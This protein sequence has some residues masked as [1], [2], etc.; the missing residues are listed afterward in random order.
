MIE[1]DLLV[2]NGL[3]VT[4]DDRQPVIEDGAV[5]IDQGR[6]VAVGPT[7]EVTG[8]YQAKK[9]L[10]ARRKAVMPGFVD[11][12]H[13]FLQ[14]FH[15]GTRDDLALIEWI[16]N[17][18]VP[19]IRVAVQDYLKGVYDIQIHASKLGC[20]DAIKSGITTIL[21]MEWATH[22]SVVSVFEQAGIRVRHTITMTD[23]WISPEVIMPHDR[24]LALADELLERC[25]SSVNGRVSFSYGLACPNSCSVG[26][27]KEVRAL[28]D[29]NQVPIHIHIAET[30]Y[31]W[32]NIHNLFGATPT[33]HLHN[34]GLLGPDVQGAH[35]IWLSDED[36]ELYRQTGTKVAH[37][38]EC[39][40]KI[41]DGIAPITKMLEAGVVVSLG[42]DSCSVNDNMDMFEAMRTAAFLQKVT[43]MDPAVLPAA[44]TL[45]M[46]TLGGAEAL[47]MENEI[48]SL[49]VGKKADLILV[50]LS[51]SHMRPINNLENSLV[52]CANANDVQTV[53]CDGQVVMEDRQILTLDEEEW[54]S[55]ATRYA[56]ERFTAAGI[57]LPSYYSL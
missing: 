36:I 30:K 51:G 52:Y 54:V 42:T 16:D 9:M 38:P 48:G 46:A 31:E 10:D 3:V 33:G 22:P 47:G 15:K 40:L 56:Y 18:S 5:A 27:I 14:N 28:S 41:A 6:I 34:L 55:Q 25:R 49:E 2:Q 20:V 4:I 53:I 37:N 21:N 23:Q 57:K 43:V 12:H 1:I 44:T 26:L 45:H 50:D 17:V 8:R 7:A 13:H 24:L 19:R 39:N 32:D 11:T 35:C 29:R